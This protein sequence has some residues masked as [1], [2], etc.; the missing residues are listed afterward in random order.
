VRFSR[1]GQLYPLEKVW[2]RVTPHACVYAAFRIPPKRAG[3]GLARSEEDT[4]IMQADAPPPRD[5][6]QEALRV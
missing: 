6:K 2:K 4:Y 5:A 3:I 1:P